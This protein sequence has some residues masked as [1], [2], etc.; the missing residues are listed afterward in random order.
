MVFCG[1]P[2][3]KTFVPHKTPAV[4]HTKWR[5][6]YGASSKGWRQDEVP[7]QDSYGTNV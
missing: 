1:L 6:S 4:L 7:F 3:G 5:T 2:G